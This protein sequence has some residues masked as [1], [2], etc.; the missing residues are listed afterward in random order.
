MLHVLNL[1]MLREKA[2]FD[3]YS[4]A[5]EIVHHTE[6]RKMFAWLAQQE[7]G[8]FNSLRKLK[9]ALT[10]EGSD[11]GFTKFSIDENKLVESMPE[12]EVSAEVSVSTTASEALQIAVEAERAS[13]E[14][15]RKVERKTTD[16]GLRALFGELVAEEQAHLLLLEAQYDAVEQGKVYNFVNEFPIDLFDGMPPL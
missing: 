3:F 4:K 13:I 10:E 1:A 7:L 9:G 15:Y 12:S 5:A 6:A 8:H 14:L 16:L 2:G 11:A